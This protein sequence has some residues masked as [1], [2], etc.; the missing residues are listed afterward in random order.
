MRYSEQDKMAELISREPVA[1]QVISRLNLPLGVGEKNIAEVC[2]EHHVHTLTFLTIVNYK[3]DGGATNADIPYAELSLQTLMEYLRNAHTYFFDFSLPMLRQ[4]LIESIHLAE[5]KTETTGETYQIPVLIIKFFDEW[6]NEI[7]THMRH[8]NERLFPYVE[9]LLKGE[10]PVAENVDK[11]EHQHSLV[12]DTHIASKL[13]ELKNMIIRYYPAMR[14]AEGKAEPNNLLNSALYDIFQHEQDLATHCAIEDNILLPAV[15]LLEKRTLGVAIEPIHEEEE[16]NKDELSERERDVVIQVVRG[17]SNKEI[18][19][20]LC[21]SPH[22]VI[23]H[24]KNIAAKLNIHST[25]GLTIYAIVNNLV[26]I[27]SLKS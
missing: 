18:A 3:A 19:E 1:L 13:T 8:E 4:K 12:D 11:Y 23:S 21:I 15:R 9:S 16:E 27:E 6:V 24:R 20:V 26:D 17:L 10:R 7:N 25:A 22:T 14:N 5:N 2:E